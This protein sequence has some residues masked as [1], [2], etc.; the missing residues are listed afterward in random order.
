M[1]A[2]PLFSGLNLNELAKEAEAKVKQELA[3][4]PDAEIIGLG[5]VG[6]NGLVEEAMSD[7]HI[8]EARVVCSPGECPPTLAD[9]QIDVSGEP[10]RDT[11]G[12]RPFFVP[13]KE[14]TYS[15]KYEGW[16]SFFHIIPPN[17][18]ANPPSGGTD[19]EHV[20]LKY[21]RE[22]PD[23]EEIRNAFLRDYDT[24]VATA[25][26]LTSAIGTIRSDVFAAASHYLQARQMKAQKDANLLEQ[27]RL[28]DNKEPIGS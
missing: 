22:K 23:A 14:V 21:I 25:K 7:F 12:K 28:H 15:V 27:L 20:F 16:R 2:R 13:A 9:T 19:E 4:I 24:L 18:L 3:K 8:R 10:L 5:I 26:D 17:V 1:D 6:L 11:R